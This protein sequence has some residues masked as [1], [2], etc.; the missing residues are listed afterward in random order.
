MGFLSAAFLPWAYKRFPHEPWATKR[1]PDGRFRMEYYAVPF[2]P[3]RPQYLRG[4]GCTDCPGYV[5]LVDSK[6][7]VILQEKYFHTGD[8]ISGGV[9]WGHQ[10]VSIKLF[11][12]WELPE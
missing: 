8:E 1:S 7:E 3:F 4:M 12:Q 5:R 10:Q 6:N 11:A 2:L 9:N